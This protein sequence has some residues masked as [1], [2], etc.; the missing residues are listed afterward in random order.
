MRLPVY[1]RSELPT[2]PGTSLS[3][4]LGDHDVL[5]PDYPVVGIITDAP[6]KG[7]CVLLNRSEKPTDHAD[8][9]T[10]H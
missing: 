8:G 5:R 9:E 6:K 7:Y 1:N 2:V 3:Y 10:D 4:S